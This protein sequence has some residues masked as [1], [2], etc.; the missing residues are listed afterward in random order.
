MNKTG[1]KY[2]QQ[3]IT[4]GRNNPESNWFWT[5]F[6]LVL[7]WPGQGTE[8]AAVNAGK[9]EGRSKL[10]KTLESASIDYEDGQERKP[11]RITDSE[12]K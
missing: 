8:L 12:Q 3:R 10:Q 7:E 6:R 1:D 2:K 4:K 11:I 5:H 9:L